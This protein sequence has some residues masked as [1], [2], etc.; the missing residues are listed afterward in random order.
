MDIPPTYYVHL[1]FAWLIVL[2]AIW[3]YFYT[4]KGAERKWSFWLLLAAGWAMFGISH[5]LT[6]TGTPTNEWYMLLIRVLGY[7][8]NIAALVNLALEAKKPGDKKPK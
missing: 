7:L 8:L 2:L 6:I 4:P 1:G 3:G 5:T